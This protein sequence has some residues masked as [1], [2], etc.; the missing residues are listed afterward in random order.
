MLSVSNVGGLAEIA[1]VPT[2]ALACP[3]L[4]REPAPAADFRVFL[5]PAAR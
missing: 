1:T 4:D 2:D 5:S 3:N